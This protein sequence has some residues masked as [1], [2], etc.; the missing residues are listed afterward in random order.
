LMAAWIAR[1]VAACSGRGQPRSPPQ[2]RTRRPSP[3][4]RGPGRPKRVSSSVA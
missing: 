4:R 1:L 2:S 3:R